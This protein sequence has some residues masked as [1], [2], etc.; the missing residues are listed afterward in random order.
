M[1]VVSL[2]KYRVHEQ[3]L[4]T[5][6]LI[7]LHHDVPRLSDKGARPDRTEALANCRAVLKHARACG[8][9]VAFTRQI[10]SPPMILKPSVYPRWIDGFG[11][12]RHDMIFDRLC[13]SC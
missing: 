2:K 7:D 10:S 12:T 5:L 3:A 9:P 11:P 8:F 1:N 6:V 13:P 4:P